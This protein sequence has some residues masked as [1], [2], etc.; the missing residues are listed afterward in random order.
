ML[1]YYYEF[2]ENST[3]FGRPVHYGLLRGFH[4]EDSDER[5]KKLH[6]EL[7]MNAQRIWVEN[8]N[9][10]T[11]MIDQGKYVYRKCPDR[12][13]TWLKLRAEELNDFI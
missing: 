6:N 3:V 2:T 5:T 11:L 8:A 12:E 13:I 10:L 4:P 9:G 7:Y 1:D